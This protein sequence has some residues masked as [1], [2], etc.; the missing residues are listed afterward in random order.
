MNY[1]DKNKKG[2][3]TL[4]S[5]FYKKIVFLRFF[6]FL[7]NIKNIGK[8]K[9]SD[10]SYFPSINSYYILPLKSPKKIFLQ[11]TRFKFTLLYFGY[12]RFLLFS[13]NVRSTKL[14]FNNVS[15]KKDTILH[16]DHHEIL[17]KEN[18]GTRMEGIASFHSLYPVN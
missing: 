15:S 11:K 12:L 2:E 3:Y 14:D 16:N 7:A 8:F 9:R 17:K 10:F 13:K 1:N 5:N 4:T 18:G 6:W